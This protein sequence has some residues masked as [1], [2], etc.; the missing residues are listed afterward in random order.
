ME[1]WS[2]TTAYFKLKDLR[3]LADGQDLDKAEAK[4]KKCSYEDGKPDLR[5]IRAI[6]VS[7]GT[8]RNDDTFL[9][10]PTW[11]ALHTINHKPINELHDNNVIVGHIYNNYT[12]DDQL[13]PIVIAS[14]EEVPDKFHVV[15]DGYIYAQ[16]L[17]ERISELDEEIAKGEKYVSM[18]CFFM[19]YYYQVGSKLI[20]RNEETSFLDKHLKSNGGK[21]LYNGVKIS[22]AFTDI[23]FGGMGIV[24]VPANP[25]SVILSAAA[26]ENFVEIEE[27]E[28]VLLRNCVLCNEER[29][30]VLASQEVKQ[31]LEENSMGTENVQDREVATLKEQLEDAKK[32]IADLQGASQQE[33]VDALNA[34]IATLQEEL[35]K[36]QAEL[37]ARKGELDVAV[38]AKADLQKELDA[39][40][41]K[42][43]D[44]ESELAKVRLTARASDLGGFDLSDDDREFFLAEVKDLDEEAYAT[45]IARANRI[46]KVKAAEVEEQEEAEAMPYKKKAEKK[47]GFPFDKKKDEKDGEDKEKKE[48]DKAKAAEEAL[49]EQL[50]D[51]VAEASFNSPEGVSV[52]ERAAAIFDRLFDKETK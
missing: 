47:G 29:K 41:A 12:V 7:T 34:T 24:D 5:Q 23:V 20:E 38:S 3:V 15:I 49:D 27:L 52:T 1:G 44:F 43:S 4:L 39:A 33:K 51:N 50:E 42:A 37:V 16:Q 9:P 26:S 22:R 40:T 11:R 31:N 18:E 19:N 36:V 45:W 21:G 17:K 8:N 10:K 35:E 30:Q 28:E 48:K 25:E 46:F 6:F 14:E 13:N 32:Q 2:K